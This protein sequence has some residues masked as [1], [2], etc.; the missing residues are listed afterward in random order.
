MIFSI[1][2]IKTLTIQIRSKN[3]LSDICPKPK[4]LQK[5]QK[6]YNWILKKKNI[7]KNQKPNFKVFKL[8]IFTEQKN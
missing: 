5:L 6:L 4:K 1:S 3:C 2:P 8:Q 7:E